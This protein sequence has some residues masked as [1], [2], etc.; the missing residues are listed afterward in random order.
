[1]KEIDIPLADMVLCG[2]GDQHQVAARL[3]SL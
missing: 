3:V 1:M 2:A